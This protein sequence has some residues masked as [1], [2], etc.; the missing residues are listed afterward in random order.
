[1]KYFNIFST[2]LVFSQSFEIVGA[3]VH[4]CRRSGHHIVAFESDPLIFE[5]VLAP[6]RDVVPSA[7]IVVPT[8]NA[9]LFD[10]DD[11]P[12]RHVAKRNRLST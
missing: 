5:A 3:F 7:S 12:I 11:V 10:E 2:W 9:A 6:L 8:M 4:A 1:M